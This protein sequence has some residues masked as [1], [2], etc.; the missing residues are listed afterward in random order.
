MTIKK[1]AACLAVFSLPMTAAAV[2]TSFNGFLTIGAGSVSEEG[3]EYA[4]YDDD[5]SFE[6]DTVS[7]FQLGAAFNDKFSITGQLVI[8][9]ADDFE[10][11]L[12]WAYL[13]YDVTDSF[14]VR[15]GRLR[16]PFFVVSDFYDVGFAYPWARPVEEVYQNIPFTHYE[17]ADVIFNTS[18][19]D[20]DATIQAYVG[21]EEGDQE[22]RGS[23]VDRKL[24]DF[25]GIA[26]TFDRQALSL[27]ASYHQA[28]LTFD[29]EQ[30]RPLLDT[31]TALGFGAVADDIAIDQK[32]ADFVEVAATYEAD[33]WF[34]RG[35]ATRTDFTRGL[36]ADQQSWY[37]TGGAYFGDFTPYVTYSQVEADPDGGY[38]DSIPFGLDPGLDVLRLTV[39]GLIA[40]SATERSAVTIGTR[41]NILDNTAIKAEITKADDKL[42]GGTDFNVYSV[43]VNVLF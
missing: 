38:A 33:A 21:G 14:T 19:G 27:R 24:E 25:M 11:E 29:I 26:F 40:G 1:L 28:D 4:G 6:P 39:E 8:R 13:S 17:G 23:N 10:P 20:W 9:G 43:V 31:L 32:P 18:F 35:E 34:A 42:A 2:E 15:A 36:V 3:I 30:V 7:G 12:E 37:V 41:W 22:Y 16:P 5:W